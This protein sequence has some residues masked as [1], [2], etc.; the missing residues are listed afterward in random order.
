MNG[1]VDTVNNF[2]YKRAHLPSKGDDV[3]L[4]P[5]FPHMFSDDVFFTVFL[6]MFPQVVDDPKVDQ[7]FHK[8]QGLTNH[9]RGKTQGLVQGAVEVFDV[10]V[11]EG[12]NLF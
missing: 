4:V 3:L 5:F 1:N 12:F 2:D 11:M 9:N 8:N 6:I 10:V 7:Q